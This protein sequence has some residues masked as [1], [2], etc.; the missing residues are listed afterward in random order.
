MFSWR[1]LTLEEEKS[2]CSVPLVLLLTQALMWS[3]ALW[4]ALK[5]M[6][7]LSHWKL[8]LLVCVKTWSR[9]KPSWLNITLAI[10][11]RSWLDL[12]VKVLCSFFSIL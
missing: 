5:S 4:G 12:A 7:L 6:L 2:R 11:T 3:A 8:S 1:R 9:G 10:K